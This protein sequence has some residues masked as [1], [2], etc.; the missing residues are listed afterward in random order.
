MRVFRRAAGNIT[1]EGP[2]K[3][4][5]KGL[6]FHR[7]ANE[8]PHQLPRPGGA[9]DNRVPRDKRAGTIVPMTGS[10][11]DG[12][13]LSPAAARVAAA[14]GGSQVVD[15]L[16]G[17]PG[18]DFTSLMLE[19]ARR[20][21]ARQ[22]RAEV[23]RRYQNDRF[24][25]PGG[26]SWRHLRWAED[27]LTR[28]LSAEFEMLT[29]SPV[30]PL[31]THSLLGP[32]SQDKILT[33]LRAVEVA[34]DPTN[35]LALEAAVRRQSRPD[36]TVRLAAFQR[37]VRAQQ[38][39]PGNAAHFSLL[40]LVT[41]GRDEGGGRRFQRD[42]VVAHI[43]AV[44]TALAEASRESVQLALTALSLAGESV[45]DVLPAGLAGAPV[46]VITDD[47]RQAGRAYYRELCF[48]I[49]IMSDGAWAEAGDGGFTDW[50]ARLTANSRE[51]LLITGIGIDRL[52]SLTAGP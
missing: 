10:S 27:L 19:V 9:A 8:W 2:G 28:P 18:S 33:T 14:V 52:V 7:A 51:R 37:V 45:A 44:A 4:R 23:L 35:A 48:K 36:E 25:R 46:Q 20:R 50:T 49:N 22:S 3:A 30:V 40:G 34:A 5:T 31:G 38:P 41:A 1:A 26:I 42:A 16:A 13:G 43:S 21:A 12:S 24:A 47:G 11:Q 29:F 15:A 6:S 32:V 39:G 17:L